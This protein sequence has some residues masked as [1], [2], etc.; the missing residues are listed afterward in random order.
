MDFADNPTF[1]VA[2]VT[3]WTAAGGHGSDAILRTSESLTRETLN[4]KPDASTPATKPDSNANVESANQHRM[5]GEKAEKLGNPLAA[6]QEYAEATR[7]DPSEQNYFAWGSELL[8]HRAVWQAK[9]VLEEGVKAY[10]TSS[11]LLTALGSTLFAGALYDDAARR[12]CEASDLNP[13]DPEPYLFMGKVEIACAESTAMRARET[14]AICA[15]E[16]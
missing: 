11:R 13:S 14:G 1:T 5:T 3:D 6:V 2:G 12:L 4:L 8:F 16:A 15:R 9:D 7:L 10:P